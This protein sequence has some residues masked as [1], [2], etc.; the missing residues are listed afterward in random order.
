MLSIWTLAS[1]RHVQN[2]IL[3]VGGHIFRI[4]GTVCRANVTILL[5]NVIEVRRHIVQS[6]ANC[7]RNARDRSLHCLQLQKL[8]TDQL[9]QMI[10]LFDFVI[11]QILWQVS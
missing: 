4:V 7:P 6:D 8:I 3:C 10:N 9:S 11:A 2:V 5:V 1:Q